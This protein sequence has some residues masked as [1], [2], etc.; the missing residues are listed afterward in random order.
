MD[1]CNDGNQ[2]IVH[3]PKANKR[4]GPY[5][6]M[7]KP[8]SYISK[9]NQLEITLK[10]GKTPHPQ[11]GRG[12]QFM[13]GFLAVGSNAKT[14]TKKAPKKGN[15]NVGDRRGAILKSVYSSVEKSCNIIFIFKT[16]RSLTLDPP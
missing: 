10:K 4:L 6:G 14:G 13:V 1:G 11:N 15:R 9:G 2:V 8:P 3:D 16:R 12:V 7:K 5:C